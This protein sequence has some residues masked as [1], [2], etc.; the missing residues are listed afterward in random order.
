[1]RELFDLSG[2][3]AVITGGAGFLGQKHAEVIAEY[4]GTPVLIDLNP[5]QLDAALKNLASQYAMPAASFVADITRED[6]VRDVYRQIMDR[7]ERIDILINNA[8]NNPKVDD[9][10]QLLNT[11]RLENFPLEL[12]LDDIAVGLTGSFLCC[13]YFGQAMATAGRGNIINISSDLGIIAPNQH[14]YEKEGLPDSQQSVKPVTYS[15]VKTGLIGLTRYL[16]TYWAEYGVRCNALCPGGVYSGQGQEFLTR[17]QT[18]IPMARM[19]QPD[20][21][22]GAVLFLASEASSYVTGA[23]I[24]VDGGRSVW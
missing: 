3:V 16:A 7:F 4:G 22:K 9:S 2:K 1:M 20:E 13:K 24:V 5:A 19:A 18:L 23:V 6:Q 17:I 21:L 14:L 8:A 15:V 11:S 10:N 12:W